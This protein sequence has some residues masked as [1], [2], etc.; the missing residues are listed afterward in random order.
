[1]TGHEKYLRTWGLSV[2][3]ELFELLKVQKDLE[4]GRGVFL[5][6]DARVTLD[7]RNVCGKFERPQRKIIPA[8]KIQLSISKR[9]FS[10]PITTNSNSNTPWATHCALPISY[11]HLRP[12]TSFRV[13]FSL[14]NFARAGAGAGKPRPSLDVRCWSSWMSL[15][16]YLPCAI[17][18]SC[19]V[20]AYRRCGENCRR[21]YHPHNSAQ[22]AV[23]RA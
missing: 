9:H 17:L 11:P 2:L 22:V 8:L 6:C 16:V 23:D 18:H 3:F 5:M 13:S 21:E 20:P 7:I 14:H 4:K 12:L 19:N 15:C 10:F 1:M